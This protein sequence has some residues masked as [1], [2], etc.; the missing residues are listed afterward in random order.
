MRP[1]IDKFRKATIPWKK[2]SIKQTHSKYQPRP[3]EPISE[4]LNADNY[5]QR[6]YTDKQMELIFGNEVQ[7][8][9]KT[10]LI[11]LIKKAESISD[12]EVVQI[13]LERYSVILFGEFRREDDLTR[14]EAL[15]EIIGKLTFDL[16]DLLEK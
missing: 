10:D 1:S 2:R 9:R 7:N 15:R 16:S 11:A 12:E 6:V 8:P 14:E 5:R 4:Q 13:L 3:T